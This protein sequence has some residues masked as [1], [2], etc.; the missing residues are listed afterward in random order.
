MTMEFQFSGAASVALTDAAAELLRAGAAA[1]LPEAWRSIRRKD[2][3]PELPPKEETGEA[4][5]T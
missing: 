3:L 2:P 1:P 4:A 5:T